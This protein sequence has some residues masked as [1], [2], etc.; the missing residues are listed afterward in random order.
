MC[1]QA[2]LWYDTFYLTFMYIVP[3]AFIVQATSHT[4]SNVSSPSE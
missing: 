1:M 3:T 2:A 4:L